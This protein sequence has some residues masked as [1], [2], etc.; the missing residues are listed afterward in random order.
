M[1]LYRC[2]LLL[3]DSDAAFT[4]AVTGD[5]PSMGT[6]TTT[7]KDTAE[8][9]ASTLSLSG[10]NTLQ[11]ITGMFWYNSAHCRRHDYSQLRLLLGS[12]L[13]ATLNALTLR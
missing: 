2:I 3:E 5:S 13:C 11:G 10:L 1:S 12:I 4:D 6:S 9:E 7:N 8:T